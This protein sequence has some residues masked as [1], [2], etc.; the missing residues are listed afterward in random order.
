[1]LADRLFGTNATLDRIG[2]RPGQRVLEIGPGPGRLL[3]PAARRIEP[4]GEA[5]GLDV[6]PEMVERLRRR[7]AQA[8]VHNLTGVVG[9]GAALPFAPERF[10][11]VFL[12]ATLG[13]IADRKAA[14]REASRVLARGGV[15]SITEGVFD[16]H[17]RPFNEVLRLAEDAGF[18]P[19]DEHRSRLGYT[20]NFTRR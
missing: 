2:L 16:P 9:D 18:A 1:P 10:D 6:Q 19:R 8:G 11:V 15:L 14:V 4:E 5:V 20:V 13:E 7:A 3:V 17:R 12:V